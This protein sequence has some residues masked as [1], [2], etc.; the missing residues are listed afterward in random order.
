[1]S[2][3][4]KY[5]S[6]KPLTL[7]VNIPENNIEMA[8]AAVQ[9]GA[10]VL[11]LNQGYDEEKILKASSVPVGLDVNDAEIKEIEKLLDLKFDFIN[12]HHQALDQYIKL[13]KAK[14]IA[15]DENYTLDNLMQLSDKKIEAIDAAIIPIS[16]SIK[17]LMVGD[18]Q[19]YIA[20]ALSSN[21]PVIIPT[22]RS[23]KPSE[24]PII[25]DTGAKGLLLTKTVIGET[26]ESIYKAVK[27]Y[28]N[29]V[30]DIDT[31]A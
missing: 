30:D 14:I 9:S 31:E 27:E 2:K 12:F 13:K 6:E 15:L 17:D 1:M 19:N 20:I 28:R 23:I 22:Q 24:V 16:Q 11:V 26:A 5:L 29:A 3:L 25:W 10:D 8:N 21:I 4:L 7:I 18:L